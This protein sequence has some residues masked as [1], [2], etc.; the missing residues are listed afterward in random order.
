MPKRIQGEAPGGFGERLARL[1]KQAGL[2]QTA[3]AHVLGISVE[4]LLGTETAKRKSKA[5]DTRMQ[6]R[7]QQIAGLPTDERRQIMQ[8]VDAFIE[9]GQLKRRAAQGENA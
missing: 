4:A 7:L 8:L 2:T 6:R 1:R 5:V 3:L 9:R